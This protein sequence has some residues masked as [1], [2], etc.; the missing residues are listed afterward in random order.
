MHLLRRAARPRPLRLRSWAPA[1]PAPAFPPLHRPASTSSSSSSPPSVATVVGVHRETGLVAA[2][3]ETNTPL[4]AG[5]IVAL[6]AEGRPGVLLWQRSLLYMFALLDD[7]PAVLDAGQ[8]SDE[9]DESGALLV[10]GSPVHLPIV[11]PPSPLGASSTAD[12]SPVAAASPPRRLAAH[13]A[14]ELIGRAHV[15][16]ASWTTP[17]S[18]H[19]A[20]DGGSDGGGGGVPHGMD[21]F[22]AAAN[23]DERSVITRPMITG[24]AAVDTLTPVGCGQSMLVVGTAGAGEL[25]GDNGGGAA[26]TATAAAAAGHAAS[27]HVATTTTTTLAASSAA[28]SPASSPAS[29]AASIDAAG[30]AWRHAFL[31]QVAAFKRRP[32]RTKSAPLPWC[33]HC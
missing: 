10:V 2:V 6:G 31:P 19:D 25:H 33:M 15:G 26:A 12:A 7:L 24:I 30:L 9:S 16:L 13:G 23:H 4:A 8:E 17:W 22:E 11:A 3:P 1:A 28:S 20:N 32:T 27:D 14:D 21:V 18:A 29:S 5:T